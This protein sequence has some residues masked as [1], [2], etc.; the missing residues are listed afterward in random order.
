MSIARAESDDRQ[1]RAGMR[2]PSSA[3]TLVPVRVNEVS[4]FVHESFAETI[5]ALL[6]LANRCLNENLSF[7]KKL[8]EQESVFGVA[9]TWSCYGV[10]MLEHYR[11]AFAQLQLVNLTLASEVLRARHLPVRSRR[12]S[13]QE[14]TARSQVAPWES[15]T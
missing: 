1:D 12:S 10:I 9:C 15:F 14:Q 7:S 13:Q 5:R 11:A 2:A 3:D 6:G 4:S 8:G